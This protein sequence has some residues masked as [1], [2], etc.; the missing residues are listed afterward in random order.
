MDS[1]PEVFRAGV[2]ANWLALLRRQRNKVEWQILL[3]FQKKRSANNFPDIGNSRFSA[4]S[5][6]ILLSI[7]LP[8]PVTHSE[9]VKPKNVLCYVQH[10][11][12]LI[13]EQNR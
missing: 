10:V 1:R 2:F 5:F 6:I 13:F 4:A 11:I 9:T 7:I 8:K 12:P 3:V